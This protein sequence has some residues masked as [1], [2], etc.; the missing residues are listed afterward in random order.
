MATR[1]MGR[2]AWGLLLIA[3]AAAI[4]WLVWRSL[5]LPSSPPPAGR[6]AVVVPGP[7]PNAPARGARVDWQPPGPGGSRQPADAGAGR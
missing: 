2:R 1:W 6:P 3:A 4:A 5:A 7:T